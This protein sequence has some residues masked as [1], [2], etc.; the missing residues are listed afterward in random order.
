MDTITKSMKID[1]VKAMLHNNG[2]N[3]PY[4]WD[5]VLGMLL[6]GCDYIKIEG[7]GEHAQ[8]VLCTDE[9]VRT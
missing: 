3:T 2:I 6:N 9:E 8:F 5:I 4:G 7:Y 1:D